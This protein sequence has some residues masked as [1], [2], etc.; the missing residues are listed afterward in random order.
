MHRVVSLVALIPL[1]VL[2]TAGSC[3]PPKKDN[4]DTPGGG[5]DRPAPQTCT[6]GDVT[7]QKPAELAIRPDGE[8]I[9]RACIGAPD[10]LPQS[11]A[12][13]LRGC[14]DVFGLGGDAKAGIL[15]DIFS[16]GADPRNDAPDVGSVEIGVASQASDLAC[17][18]ADAGHPA[19]LAVGELDCD[20]Q[21]A[22]VMEDVP[23]H[24]PLTMKVHKPGDG[25]VIDTYTF[26]VV[27]GY[28]DAVVR[29]LDGV[30]TVDYSANLIYRSTYDSIP[31]LA[32]RIVEG[33]QTIGDGIGRGVIAG[34]VHDCQDK[35]VQGA[36]VSTN[37]ADAS[38]KV[39]YFD[40]DVEDPS[41]DLRRS[42]TNTDG[43]YVILN[44]ATAEGTN[45]HVVA[46]AMIDPS[47][48][49]A[50]DDACQCVS[51]S[52]RTVKAYPDSVSIVTLRGDLPVLE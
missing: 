12:V 10:A 14:I 46:A 18:G 34:E 32:G 29:E 25:I 27:F 4:G 49:D 37:Q 36:T 8:E 23:L 9:D 44:A 28:G 48:A 5:G 42:S 50:A 33:Q 7:F 51:L 2:T 47:C 43:L 6:A 52:S 39:T 26:G 17:N 16:D 38:T 31:T 45:E 22:Y 21:G 15:V 11:T 19:C 1:T 24:V 35:V 3:E 40:G 41:P 13:R 20:K 30:P